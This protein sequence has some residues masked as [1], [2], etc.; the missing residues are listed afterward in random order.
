MIIHMTQLPFPGFI[1]D[2]KG[3]YCNY[4]CKVNIKLKIRKSSKEL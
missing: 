1:I 2:E 4:F 3:A